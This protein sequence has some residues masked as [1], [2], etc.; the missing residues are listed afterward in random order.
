LV[1]TPPIT[2]VV[3]PR[4]R[5]VWSNPVDVK[6]PSEGWTRAEAFERVEALV[7][8]TVRQIYTLASTEDLDT[9]AAALRLAEQQLARARPKTHK[10]SLCFEV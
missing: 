1:T 4:L 2:K 6:V 5:K 8:R 9:H 10:T 7:D 3:I